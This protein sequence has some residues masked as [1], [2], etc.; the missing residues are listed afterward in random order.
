MQEK[1]MGHLF[2][3]LSTLDLQSMAAKAKKQKVCQQLTAV[4]R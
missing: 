3:T 1:G 2:P 4:D